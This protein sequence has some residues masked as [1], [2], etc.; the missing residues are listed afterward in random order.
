MCIHNNLVCDDNMNCALDENGIQDQSDE[1][2]CAQ[3]SQQ[4]C[5]P[6]REFQCGNGL[7]IADEFKCDN[8]DDCGDRS[9]E[10]KNCGTFFRNKEY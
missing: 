10:K 9:D 8:Y 5:E 1:K 4:T 7:C 3:I 2:M 6:R